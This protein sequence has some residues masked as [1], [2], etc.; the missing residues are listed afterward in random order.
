MKRFFSIAL[1]LSL[2]S[3]FFI[4]CGD[5][6]VYQN[7]IEFPNQKW[8]RIEEGKD[9]SF[10]KI[11]ITNIKDVY[12]INVSFD[13]TKSINVDEISFVLRIISPSGIKKESVHNV[14]LKDRN[15]E[16]FIGSDLGDIVEIKEPIKQYLTFTEKGDYKFIIT[17]VSSKYQVTGLKNIGIEVKKSVL[18]YNVEK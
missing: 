1:L 12:D 2:V 7:E 14:A 9:I 3:V 15:A 5:K 8:E 18:D 6:F 17:N 4:S 13:H 11:N 10:E 16:K